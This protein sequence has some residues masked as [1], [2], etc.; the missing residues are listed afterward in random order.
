MATIQ[1]YSDLRPGA[2]VGLS[3]D[4]AASV[5]FAKDTGERLQT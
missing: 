3:F 4:C 1:G 2:Q 5:L